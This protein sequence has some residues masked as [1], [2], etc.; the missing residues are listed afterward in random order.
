MT[1][2][3]CAF[4]EDSASELRVKERSRFHKTGL[5]KRARN[6]MSKTRNPTLSVGETARR[7]RVSPNTVRNYCDRGWLHCIRGR[8]IHRRISLRS[9]ESFEAQRRPDQPTPQAEKPSPRVFRGFCM[10]LTRTSNSIT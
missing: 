1:S 8:G 7:L 9:I 2:E 10:S 3:L 6:R 5:A 4:F